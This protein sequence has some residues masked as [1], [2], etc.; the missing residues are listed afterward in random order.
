M[1]CIA[2]PLALNSLVSNYLSM[3]TFVYLHLSIKKL[4]VSPVFS[5]VRGLVRHD[6]GG[7]QAGPDEH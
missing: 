6:T 3:N 4:P 7:D 1:H 2:C 5:G